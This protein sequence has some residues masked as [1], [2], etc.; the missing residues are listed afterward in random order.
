MLE[1]YKFVFA[2]SFKP[3]AV[4]DDWEVAQENLRQTI[5][6][7]RGNQK[8]EYLIVIA[9]HDV[10]DLRED[11]GSDLHVLVVPYATEFDVLQRRFDVLTREDKVRKRYYIGAW[12][13][14]NLR[15]AGVY[16]MFLDADDYVHKDIVGHVLSHD[17]RRSYFAEKGYEYD[18]SAGILGRRIFTGG[19]GS[20]FISY[21]S[22]EELPRSWDDKDSPYTQFSDHANFRTVAAGQGKHADSIP[23]DAVVYLSNHSESLR[24]KR[25]LKRRELELFNLVWPSQAKAILLNDFSLRDVDRAVSGLAGIGSFFVGVLASAFRRAHSRAKAYALRLRGVTKD[26]YYP[27]SAAVPGPGM[28]ADKEPTPSDLCETNS[29]D[30]ALGRDK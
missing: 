13:R 4:S 6:S 29:L 3:R 28:A 19:F 18:C 2:I 17:N 9:C 10:P 24:R 12:L 27:P 23:F 5:R 26:E 1:R 20:C 11:S 30:K 16:V 15:A 7:I 25:G 21:F 14:E 22:K 8:A